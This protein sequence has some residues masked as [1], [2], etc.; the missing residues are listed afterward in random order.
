MKFYLAHPFGSRLEIRLWQLEMEKKYNIKM[1]NAFFDTKSES[2]WTNTD[3][4]NNAYFDTLNYKT[5]VND[6]LDLIKKTD[7]MI[8]IINDVLS[9]GTIQEIVY[10]HLYKKKI[11]IICT[12]GKDK[13]PWLRYHA[14]KMFISCD[15]FE[16]YIKEELKMGERQTTLDEFI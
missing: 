9:Y 8:A 16:I 13:H 10:A 11:F 3:T 5:I 1:F 6:D 4:N 12:N 2:T 14:T 15:D 7:V